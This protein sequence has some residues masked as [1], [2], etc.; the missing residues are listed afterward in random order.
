VQPLLQW[1]TISIMYC[2]CVFVA[3]GTQHAKRMRPIIL[4]SVV[5]PA[6]QH[7]STLSHKRHD[8]RKQKKKFTEHKMC[9]LIFFKTFCPKHSK[10]ARAS[11]YKKCI[12]IFM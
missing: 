2:E 9:I 1:K 12:L 10:K 11:Y 7:S 5:C 6:V 4:S 8:F 3:L